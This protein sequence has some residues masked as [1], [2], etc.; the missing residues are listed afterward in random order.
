MTVAG[1][2]REPAARVAA[3]TLVSAA[4]GAAHTGGPMHRDLVERA[5]A[6][7][8]DAFSE[9]ARLSSIG[10]APSPG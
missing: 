4:R 5:M 8:H 9:L 3:L 1:A 6:G 2:K 7:D 10:S